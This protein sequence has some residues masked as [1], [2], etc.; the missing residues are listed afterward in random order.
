VDEESAIGIAS[1][2][3]EIELSAADVRNCAMSVALLEQFGNLA[4]ARRKLL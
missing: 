4:V 2:R 3:Y 1:A